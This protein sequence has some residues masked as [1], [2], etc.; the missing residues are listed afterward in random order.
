MANPN[1]ELITSKLKA[2]GQEWKEINGWIMT[3]CMNPVH[4]DSKLTHFGINIQSF[5]GNCFSCGYKSS[6]SL[7]TD[8]ID[9]D[10]MLRTMKYQAILSARQTIVEEETEKTVLLPPKFKNL[11]KDWRGLPVEFLTSIGIYLC[12]RG[13]FANRIIF[14]LTVDDKVVGIDARAGK[15]GVEPKYLRNK[16]FS[17]KNTLY[18]YDLLKNMNCDTII[19]VEGIMDALSYIYKGFPAF[20]NFGLGAPSNKKIAM[21]HRLGVSNIVNGFDN[22][23]AGWNAWHGAENKEGLIVCYEEHFNIVTHPEV[24]KLRAS[25]F[26]DYNDYIKMKGEI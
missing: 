15:V 18:P 6:P 20:C 2:L 13:R 14:P 11:D 21:L 25:E 19:I 26:K 17:S 9:D 16:G 7:F 12:R 22:D 3:N 5:K 10:E 23:E 24:E 8:A 1:L 4:N